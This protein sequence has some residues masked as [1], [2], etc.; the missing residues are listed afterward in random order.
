LNAVGWAAFA[1]VC[2]AGAAVGYAVGV[3]VAA[4]AVPAVLAGAAVAPVALVWADRRRWR[5]RWTGYSWGGTPVEV[6]HAAGELRRAG[7]PAEAET[8]GGRAA[9]RYRNRDRRRVAR[10]LAGL[11]IQPPRRW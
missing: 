6:R 10:V 5:R 3:A 7:V 8:T 2:L 9:L 1:G 11:G 4:P